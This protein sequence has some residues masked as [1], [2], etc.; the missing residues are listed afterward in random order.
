MA[1]RLTSRRPV[2]ACVL[3]AGCSL[4]VRHREIRVHLTGLPFNDAFG[5]SFAAMDGRL[6]GVSMMRRGLDR[7]NGLLFSPAT[8]PQGATCRRAAN[9]VRLGMTNCFR[10]CR[11]SNAF[12]AIGALRPRLHFASRKNQLPKGLRVTDRSPL[13]RIPWRGAAHYRASDSSGATAAGS[14][15]T[16]GS[17]LEACRCCGA[18]SRAQSFDAPSSGLARINASWPPA[19][20]VPVQILD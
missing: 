3:T 18:K 13:A 9:A 7:A 8:M 6:A 5:R 11:V 15:A 19:A 17:T 12:S 10:L 16:P 20:P 14:S 1:A 2:F 4:P